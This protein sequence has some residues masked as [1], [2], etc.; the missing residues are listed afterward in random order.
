VKSQDP[1][2]AL[3]GLLHLLQMLPD[4][5]DRLGVLIIDELVRPSRSAEDALSEEH[6]YCDVHLVPTFMI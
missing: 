6:W 2:C 1:Q 3:D 5:D 4:I